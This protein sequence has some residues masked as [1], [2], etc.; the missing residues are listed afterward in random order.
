MSNIIEMINVTKTFPGIIAN[1]NITIK[2]KE[3]EIHALLGE[4]GAGKSTLM[5]VLF[6]MYKQ[7]SGDIIIEGV[8]NPINNPNEAIKH[9]IG[10][11]HQ[12]FMLVENMTVL[13][14]I[15]LG[16]EP[17]K[18]FIDK[19][20]ARKKVL[21][22]SKKYNMD[23]DLDAKVEDITVG[24]QQRIEILKILYRDAKILVFDE[25]T[26][27]LT[28]Q[29][30]EELMDIIRFL[31][32]EGKTI[33]IITH[34]IDEIKAIAS[35]CTIIRRGKVIDTVDVNNYTKKELAEIMVGREINFT[36]DKKPSELKDVVL[37]INNLVVKDNRKINKVNNLSLEVKSGEILGIAGVDG[38]GQTELIESIVGLRAI[39]SGSIIHNNIDIS[40]YSIRDRIDKGIGHIPQDR[41]KFGLVLDFELQENLVLQSYYNSEYQNKGI[42]KKD[43]VYETSERLIDEYDIRS[44]ERSYTHTAS[45]S[46]GNQQKAIIARELDSSPS[47]LLAGQPTRGLDV[48][49]IEFIHKKLI[50]ERD[51][52]KAILLISL[53]LDEILN[54]SDTIAVI[55]EGQIVKVIKNEN[56]TKEELGILMSTKSTRNDNQEKK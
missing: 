18:I 51:K 10:M 26:A 6:G 43:K 24:M 49:A 4:N 2:V 34:K 41:H 5:S 39:E 13:D 25:P 1:D 36:I 30:I 52:G 21:D 12:H 53:E 19:K 38:N 33:I 55:Y 32:E 9:G 8:K 15:I 7:D 48:G 31:K 35:R 23:I 37:K 22:L 42:I 17:G 11:V 16:N 27:V 54:I 46:G 50:E 40:N 29:E 56:V 44:G 47:L 45:M 20:K 28:P 3:N 14:N